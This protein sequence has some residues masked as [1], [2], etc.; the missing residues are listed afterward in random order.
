MKVSTSIQ[1][2]SVH[3]ASLQFLLVLLVRQLE[4]DYISLLDRSQ[5]SQYIEVSGQVERRI[6]F[7]IIPDNRLVECW[8]CRGAI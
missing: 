5:V 4:A 1:I 8:L 3:C 7:E 2:N 6:D